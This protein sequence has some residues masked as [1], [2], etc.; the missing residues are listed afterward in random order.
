[1]VDEVFSHPRLLIPPDASLAILTIHS[2]PTILTH[3]QFET[4]QSLSPF[5]L[6]FMQLSAPGLLSSNPPT[7]PLG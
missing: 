4:Y 1:M 2:I 3:L 7:P 6:V 5:W